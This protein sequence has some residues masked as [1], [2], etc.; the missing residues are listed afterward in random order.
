MGTETEYGIIAPAL[1]SANPTL[2]SSQVVNA[3]AATLREGLGNLAGTRWDYTD[4]TPLTDARGFRMDRASAHPSQ[5][6]D[7]PPELTAEQIALERGEAAE[8]AVLMNLVLN[9]GARLYVDHAHP[10]YSSPEV[11]NPLDAVLWDRAGDHVAVAA[12]ERIGT[13]PGFSPVI[14]YKNNTDNKSVSYGSH[15]NYLVPRSVP[16]S[17]LAETLIP[18][19]VSRQVICGAGRVGKGPLNQ[20][21]GFQISQRADFFENEIGLETT[22][23]RPIINTRDEPHAVAEK[24]RRLHVI[25]GDANLNE[26]SNYLKLGTTS[27]VLALVEQGLAPAPTL[28]DPVQALRTISHDPTLKAAVRLAD[29]RSITG[30]E[31]QELYCEAVLD[32]VPAD[33]DEQTRDVVDRWRTL[34]ETLRREPM[35]AARQVD[36]IAKLK[37]LEAYRAR[38]GLSWTNPRL[39]LVDLQYADLRPEKGIYQRLARRGDVELLVHPEDV[40]RAAVQPPRDTRA[41]FRGRCISEYPAEVVGASWDSLIFELAGERRLQRV[42]TREPLR[43]TA[44]LTEELF[45]VAADAEDFLARLL[46]DPDRRVAP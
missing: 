29:G 22:V 27:L 14:L 1:P 34:L 37:V 30:L 13:T 2:L 39:A 44:M 21:P 5:L 24:Y 17:K 16:F 12:M 35:E 9:N 25:I 31:L 19:F 46:S 20:E 26:V 41:Y 11:T 8:A 15:E 40:A 23:R 38:D 10:E 42:Q 36:W 7:E 43:G 45:D 18:F 28:E 33:A 32:A 3:Y 6:T 4:E